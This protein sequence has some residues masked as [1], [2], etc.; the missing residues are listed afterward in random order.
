ME[1]GCFL[2]SSSALHHSRPTTINFHTAVRAIFSKKKWFCHF[3][4]WDPSVTSYC[5]EDK[6]HSSSGPCLNLQLHLLPAPPSNTITALQ[7]HELS[8][9]LRPGI[10]PLVELWIFCSLFCMSYDSHSFILLKCHFL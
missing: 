6:D 9:L 1:Q 4:A 3:H 8:F 5:Y 2:S 7:T 10:A